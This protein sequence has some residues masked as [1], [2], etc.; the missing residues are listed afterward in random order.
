MSASKFFLEY[1]A[2]HE[3]KNHGVLNTMD[4]ARGFYDPFVSLTDIGLT[5]G[6]YRFNDEAGK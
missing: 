3:C 6:W 1:T 5:P 2:P 4:R